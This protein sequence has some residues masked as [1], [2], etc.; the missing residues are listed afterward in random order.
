MKL[1]LAAVICRNNQLRYAF[2]RIVLC[3][4][5]HA[6]D[7]SHDSRNTLLTVNQDLLAHSRLAMKLSLDPTYHCY[8]TAK[9]GYKA[10]RYY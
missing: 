5:L 7:G 2:L 6:G 9:A 3:K 10:E 4:D 8:V 1:W